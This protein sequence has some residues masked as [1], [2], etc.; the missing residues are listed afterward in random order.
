MKVIVEGNKVKIFGDNFGQSK[1]RPV[2]ILIYVNDTTTGED[3]YSISML[4][5][6]FEIGNLPSITV[7]K[8]DVVIQN[9]LSF[10][11]SLVN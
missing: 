5:D 2:G 1:Q 7:S 10:G 9:N 3:Y 4:K 8:S 11:R 6:C